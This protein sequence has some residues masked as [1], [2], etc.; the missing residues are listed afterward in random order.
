[1]ADVLRLAEAAL[2]TW[3]AE[4][5]DY[6][7]TLIKQES[8]GGVV[9]EPNEVSIKVQCRH[10]GPDRQE[11]QPMRVY[12]RFDQPSGVAGREV[13]WCEDLHDGK[14]V[15]H[16]GGLMGLLTV[17][18]DP[19]GMLAMR[20]QRYPI[21]EI[22]LTNL[23]KQLVQRGEQDR[24]NPDVSVTRRGGLSG[25]PQAGSPASIDLIEVRRKQ[26]SGAPDDFSLAR[27][28]FDNERSLPF[29]Y[30]A[31]GWPAKGTVTPD[32]DGTLPISELPLLE[33]YAYLNLQ[34]NVG[35][36]DKD[37]DPTN[38]DYQYR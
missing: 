34:T 3:Q 29:K 24:D 25:D 27:I 28:Y 9:G 26:P 23:Y 20:G 14:L 37:F 4:V 30:E 10:R 2:S 38:P 8:V 31:Y 21:T 6:T 35:L 22:G 36:S 17:R 18:L 32:A 1:M 11:T 13:I 19:T 7:A 16:E 33:S 15:A 12:L 5:D